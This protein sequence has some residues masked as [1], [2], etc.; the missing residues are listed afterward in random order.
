[1]IALEHVQYVNP[2][3]LSFSTEFIFFIFEF[4]LQNISWIHQTHKGTQIFHFEVLLYVFT[5]MYFLYSGMISKV[6]IFACHVISFALQHCLHF[7]PAWQHKKTFR[8]I[9]AWLLLG[10]NMKVAIT[11]LPPPIREKL[12]AVERKQKLYTQNAN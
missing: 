5:I 2:L 1:M 11:V 4:L 12:T 7:S 6:S 9:N 8:Y 10:L 3:A